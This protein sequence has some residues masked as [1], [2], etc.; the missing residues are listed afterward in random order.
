[1]ESKINY[2]IHNSQTMETRDVKRQHNTLSF[3]QHCTNKN[4]YSI[5]NKAPSL[6]EDIYSNKYRQ[7]LRLV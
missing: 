2:R 6:C 5:I 7:K 1:M 4:N 3:N